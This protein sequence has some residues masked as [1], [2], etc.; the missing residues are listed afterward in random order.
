M[1]IEII[2]SELDFYIVEKIRELRIKAGLDQVTLAQKLGVSEGYIG[3]IENPKNKAKANIRLLAR[4]AKALEMESY[5]NFFPVEILRED[6][7][8]IKI[9]LLDISSRSQILDEE[10]RVPKRLE[11]LETTPISTDEFE[12]LKSAKGG[13]KYCTIIKK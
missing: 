13:L 7:V 4:I 9:E 5:I 6:M 10:G 11:I 3:N 2:T 12:K 8:R 1:I